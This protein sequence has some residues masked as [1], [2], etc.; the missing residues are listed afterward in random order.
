[1]DVQCDR[2]ASALHARASAT[3]TRRAKLLV[4][5]AAICAVGIGLLFWFSAR[6]RAG[7]DAMDS[8]INPAPDGLL[9]PI[10]AAAAVCLLAGMNCVVRA[11]PT[12]IGDDSPE[13]VTRRLEVERRCSQAETG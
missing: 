8:Q 3:G 6:F 2:H 13:M 4:V 9:I 10:L 11:I 1:M 7:M 12:A 5:G